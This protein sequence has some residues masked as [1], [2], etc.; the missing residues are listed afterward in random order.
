MLE[1]KKKLFS[2]VKATVF[3]NQVEK[4]FSLTNVY[5]KKEVN[6][7]NGVRAWL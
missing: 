5:N 6:F 7:I 3:V 2:V 4:S 1:K